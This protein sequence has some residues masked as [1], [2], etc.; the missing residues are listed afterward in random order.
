MDIFNINSNWKENFMSF[1]N[2]YIDDF[3]NPSC[4]EGELKLWQQYWMDYKGPL[5]NGIVHTLKSVNFPGFENIK[6][7]QVVCTKV[8][9]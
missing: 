3:P 8:Q 1:V 6:I 9:K 5:P 4:L 7:A 2:V